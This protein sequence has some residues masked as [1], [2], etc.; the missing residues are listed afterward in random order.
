MK[1]RQLARLKAFSLTLMLPGMAGLIV[2]AMIS[3]HYL[4]TMPQWPAPLEMRTVPR[5]VHGTVI[6][7][8]AK[9][10]RNLDWIEFSSVGVFLA[11]L[12]LGLTYLEQWGARQPL[13]VKDEDLIAE[14]SSR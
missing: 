2:A 7:Q 11:G 4:E 12:A 13:K 1:S 5:N 9:E 3:G 14:D 6:Y 10:A 8:T